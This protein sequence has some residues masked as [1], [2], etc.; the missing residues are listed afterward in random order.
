M[1]GTNPFL[2]RLMKDKK[3]DVAHSSA[4]GK[5]QNARGIGVASTESFATRRAMNR[6]RTMV[7]RYDESKV[8]TEV[9]DGVPKA[10][11]YDAEQDKASL[12]AVKTGLNKEQGGSGALG[13]RGKG[14]VLDKSGMQEAAMARAKMTNR[15][16]GSAPSKGS[17][18]PPARRNPGIS[19]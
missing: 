8:V 4:Y 1:I 18:A 3:E 13:Q 6:N 19:R 5:V 16:A 14:P 10:M 17:S 2:K 7:R 11:K 15:F 9:G 12:D